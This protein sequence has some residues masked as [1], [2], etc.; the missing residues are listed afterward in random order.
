M[1]DFNQAHVSHLM[2]AFKDGIMS[3]FDF[4][5]Y[6]D[7]HA[8]VVFFGVYSRHDLS[9][10]NS[11]KGKKIV[12]FMGV[13]MDKHAE[14]VNRN[15]DTYFVSYDTNTYF[16]SHDTKTL[17]FWFVSSL[18]FNPQKKR[19]KKTHYLKI[20]ITFVATKNKNK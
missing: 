10:V 15:S 8:P 4:D 5:A 6:T 3:Q 2:P 20:W 14:R 12:V 7:V 9:V 17:E 16:V 19:V 18:K 1:R 13:D 11:H